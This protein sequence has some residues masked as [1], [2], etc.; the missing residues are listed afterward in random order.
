MRGEQLMNN[1]ELNV[2][3]QQ[4]ERDINRDKLMADAYIK[5]TISSLQKLNKSEM[6]A[7]TKVVKY[8]LPL[9]VRCKNFFN[10]LFN[11]FN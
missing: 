9:K 4:L 1:D 11:T 8:R 2:E 5:D 3:I 10:K 6:I 7:N